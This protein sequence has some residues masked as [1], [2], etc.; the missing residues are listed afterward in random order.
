M[1]GLEYAFGA[2]SI[3][4]VFIGTFNQNGFD[5][6]TIKELLCTARHHISI[7]FLF[8][9]YVL[10]RPCTGKKNL[11]NLFP[12]AK[13]PKLIELGILLRTLQQKRNRWNR[14]CQNEDVQCFTQL[15][16]RKTKCIFLWNDFCQCERDWRSSFFS[17]WGCQ[18]LPSLANVWKAFR[19]LAFLVSL[20][21]KLLF[22][23]RK[24]F[25]TRSAGGSLLAPG[26]L[27]ALEL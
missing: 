16:E 24:R 7:Q 12:E 23:R 21:L 5:W 17:S 8:V 26:P 10:L 6:N 25:K 4:T 18:T 15:M 1:F 19:L 13:L 11:S 2:N 27:C 14:T 22:W 9:N 20:L 3:K